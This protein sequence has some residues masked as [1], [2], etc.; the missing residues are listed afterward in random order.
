MVAQPR[1]EHPMKLFLEDESGTAAIEYALIAI[2]IAIAIVA[3]VSGIG[4]E[5]KGI[6]EDYNDQMAEHRS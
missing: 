4:D 2:G 3:V 5:L 6:F 1:M